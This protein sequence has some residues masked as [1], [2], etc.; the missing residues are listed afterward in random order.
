M[1]IALF[2][3]T[4]D[5]VHQGHLLMAEAARQAA[6]LDRIVWLPAGDPPHKQRP[7]CSAQNRLAMVRLAV[8][9]NRAFA[10]SDWEI[11]Q[12]RVTYTQETLTHFSRVWRGHS[13]FFLVGTDSLK[14]IRSWRGGVDLLRRFSF[15]VVERPGVPWTSIVPG[16]RRLVQRVLSPPIPFASHDIRRRVLR[17]ESIRYQVPESVERYIRQHRFY[18]EPE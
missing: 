9:G 12:K 5:P 3:G 11:R 4:F 17:R 2:G 18:R 6:H 10:V 16:H 13:L 7:I 8:R 1:R 15:L 14:P